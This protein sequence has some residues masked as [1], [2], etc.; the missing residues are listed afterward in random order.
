MS[1]LASFRGPSTPTSSP[2]QQ[3]K[4]QRHNQGKSTPSSPSKQVESTYHRKVRT[5]L[6]EIRTVTKTW[7]DLVLFDGLKSLKKLVNTRTDLDDELA[8]TPDRLPRAHIVAPDL[9]I[10]DQ[11]IAELDTIIG[12]L[13]KQF[14]R[15]NSSIET[16]ESVVVEAHKA[17]GW[18]WVHEEPL[19]VTWSLEKFATS[20]SDI[21]IPYH[22]SL[23]SHIEIVN[24][25]RHHSASFETSREAVDEWV[26]QPWLQEGGWGTRWEDICDAEVE[27][28]EKA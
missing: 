16:L 7:E 22:R 5:C 6:Q 2:V 13:Q 28:W 11:C 12:K 17:K 24:V 20:I 4:Q 18:Q 27:R 14:R 25:L 9:E 3:A 19:W 10:M 15:L 1:R 26:T 8:R 23:N 21:I